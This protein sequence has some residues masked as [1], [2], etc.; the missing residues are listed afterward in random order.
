VTQ[1]CELLYFTK[2]RIKRGKKRNT[3]KKKT[4]KKENKQAYMNKE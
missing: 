3:G 4:N 1:N 2:F